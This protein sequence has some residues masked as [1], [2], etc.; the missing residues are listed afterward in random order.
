MVSIQCKQTLAH[1]DV[2][3]FNCQY[4]SNCTA[5]SCSYL[6]DSG[7]LLAHYAGSYRFHQRLSLRTD[8]IEVKERFTVKQTLQVFGKGKWFYERFTATKKLYSIKPLVI[9]YLSCHFKVVISTWQLSYCSELLGRKKAKQRALIPQYIQG[10]TANQLRTE[11]K[12]P[13]YQEA[14]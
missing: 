11:I 13:E 12:N 8:N 5:H 7:N 4:I 6:G 10:T 2:L 9:K 14:L 3:S 1:Y